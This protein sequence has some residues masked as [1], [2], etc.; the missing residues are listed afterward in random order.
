M[1]PSPPKATAV[2]VEPSTPRPAFGQQLSADETRAIAWAKANFG[3]LYTSDGPHIDTRIQQLL[4]FDLTVIVQWGASALEKQGA[5]VETVAR[6]QRDLTALNAIGL[7]AEILEAARPPAAPT[8]V[9]GAIKGVFKGQGQP[10]A[11]K[12]AG[13]RQRIV[14]VRTGLAALQGQVE[15][16]RTAWK[17]AGNRLPVQLAAL[18][19]AVSA[20]G[21]SHD[22]A[23]STAIDNRRRTLQLA[24]TQR[25]TLHDQIEEMRRQIVDGQDRIDQVL[26]VTLPALEAAHASSGR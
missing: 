23:L 21:D 10:L 4:P 16:A 14:A 1:P 2:R 19:A 25:Q 22:S 3:A 15:A 26:T 5:L 7:T 24:T 11:A 9:L 13:F 8:G 20:V 17:D 6:L 18:T 12:V